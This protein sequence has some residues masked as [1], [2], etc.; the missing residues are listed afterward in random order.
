M[1]I[2]GYLSFCYQELL[3]Y[4]LLKAITPSQSPGLDKSHP[5]VGLIVARRKLTGRLIKF[6]Y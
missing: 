4:P 1:K 3:Y 5:L 6:D 2:V